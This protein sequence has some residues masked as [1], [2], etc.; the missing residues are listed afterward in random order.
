M[1]D[2]MQSAIDEGW[3]G[4]GIDRLRELGIVE[5]DESDGAEA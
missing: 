2:R 4:I 3:Y 1:A 5:A